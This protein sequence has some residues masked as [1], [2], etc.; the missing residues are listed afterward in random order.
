MEQTK[1]AAFWPV[2][3]SLNKTLI[4][5]DSAVRAF[6]PM[7]VVL[8]RSFSFSNIAS[9]NI[10]DWWLSYWISHDKE[11]KSAPHNN[12]SFGFPLLRSMSGDES[13]YYRYNE[14]HIKKNTLSFYL[15]VYGGIGVANS[16]RYGINYIK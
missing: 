15:V 16:V 13:S 3:Q 2:L 9:R 10:S 12:T 4:D 8:K 14:L 11:S 7:N 5:K 1:S 6:D